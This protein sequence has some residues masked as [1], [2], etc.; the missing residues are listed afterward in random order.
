MAR[1]WLALTKVHLKRKKPGLLGYTSAGTALN[2]VRNLAGMANNLSLEQLTVE[3]D[4]IDLSTDKRI[5]VRMDT[6]P[7]QRVP[8]L[9]RYVLGGR[10]PG[11]ALVRTRPAA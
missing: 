11:A 4:V 10:G 9:G 7:G 6:R 2:G 5:A 1:I 8:R 3:A